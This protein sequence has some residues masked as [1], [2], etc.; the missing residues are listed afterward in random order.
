MAVAAVLI[1]A[2]APT[3]PVGAAAA[4]LGEDQ[5]IDPEAIP[6]VIDPR[7][8]HAAAAAAGGIATVAA[9]AATAAVVA[10]GTPTVAAAAAAAAIT[11]IAPAIAA[12][13]VA[14]LIVVTVCACEK[15]ISFWISERLR[16]IS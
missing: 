2:A 10:V 4:T 5:D 6:I 15:W 14:A 16:R 1:A 7:T 13:T 3:H 11:A 8:T 9:A 12:A